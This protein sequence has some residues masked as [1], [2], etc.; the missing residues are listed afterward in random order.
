MNRA[1]SNTA[2]YGPLVTGF[3]V[4]AAILLI[5]AGGELSWIRF[6]VGAV[7]FIGISWGGAWLLRQR[8]DR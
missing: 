5:G 4:L 7:A 1:Q 2:F 6:A 3:V 8:F